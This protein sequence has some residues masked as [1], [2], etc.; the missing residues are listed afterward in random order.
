MPLL[1]GPCRKG[2]SVLGEEREVRHALQLH[3]AHGHA[4]GQLHHGVAVTCEVRHVL[5]LCLVEGAAIKLLDPDLSAAA[6]SA[7]A[8]GAQ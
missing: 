6:Y 2:C 1:P 8:L 7:Q 4:K 5:A 3:D